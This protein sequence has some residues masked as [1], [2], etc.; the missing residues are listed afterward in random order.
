MRISRPFAGLVAC[1]S[2]AL[3]RALRRG[4]VMVAGL[5][6]I[7]VTA[8]PLHAQGLSPEEEAARKAS[9]PLGSVRAIMTDNTIAFG[10]GESED[11]TTFGF[12]VQPVYSI[13]NSTKL[14]M[15]ARAVVPILGLEPGVVVPPIGGEPRPP[16]ASKWGLS[17]SFLQFFLSPKTDGSVKFGVGPQLSLKT[18]TSDRQA[19]PGWGAGVGA[20]VFG[21]AGQLSYGALVAQHWGEDFSLLTVQP[22][23]IYLFKSLPGAYV[24]YNNSMTYDWK[25]SEGNRYTLP[26]GLTFGK[27][28]VMESGDFWDLGVGVYPLVVRPERAAKW[29]LKVGVS[30]FF[31]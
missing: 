31:N 3:E 19:G 27:A 1:V 23:V 15:I 30:Y 20:V 16:G 11:D 24:G 18:R 29:Q 22:I 5:A 2:V 13:P 28:V 4:L 14:N 26:L 6:A 8:V 21:S 10:A 7:G 17:D 9:D 25:A 12:Q